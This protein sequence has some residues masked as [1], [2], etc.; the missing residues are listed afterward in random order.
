MSIA[1]RD[2]FFSHG[3][4]GW[5]FIRDNVPYISVDNVWI[6]QEKLNEVNRVYTCVSVSLRRLISR[7]MP[8]GNDD[9]FW[10]NWYIAYA[11]CKNKTHP[12]DAR[13]GDARRVVRTR[14]L[15]RPRRRFHLTVEMIFLQLSPPPRDSEFRQRRVLIR[16]QRVAACA[17]Y[18]ECTA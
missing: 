10:S 11:G 13:N 8:Q 6:K 17:R 15:M 4:L 18:Y 7:L 14:V 12:C 1:R 16:F 9:T 5:T 2:F 3:I